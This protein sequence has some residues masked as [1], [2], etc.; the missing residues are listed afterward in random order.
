MQ[1]HSTYWLKNQ[2]RVIMQLSYVNRIIHYNKN[3]KK[4]SGIIYQIKSLMTCTILACVI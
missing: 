2:Q 1:L 4:L 3:I